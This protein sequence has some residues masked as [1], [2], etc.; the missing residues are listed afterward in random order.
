MDGEDNACMKK[1]GPGGDLNAVSPVI[2]RAWINRTDK[3][4]RSPGGDFSALLLAVDCGNMMQ[5]D[6][7]QGGDQK[8]ELSAVDRGEIFRR[9]GGGG[10]GRTYETSHQLYG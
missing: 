6:G 9:G 2:E 3:S 8:A 5:W 7:H 4:D 1:R 10:A